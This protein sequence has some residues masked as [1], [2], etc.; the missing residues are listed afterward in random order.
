MA[1]DN[2]TTYTTVVRDW[3][4]CLP[5][6]LQRDPPSIPQG[7]DRPGAQNAKAVLGVVVSYSL[8]EARQHFLGQQFRLRTHADYPGPA[9]PIKRPSLQHAVRHR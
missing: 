3:R 7:G 6:P 5:D 9:V 8:D 4:D 2:A 1:A